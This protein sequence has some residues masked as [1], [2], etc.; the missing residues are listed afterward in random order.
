MLANGVSTRESAF[1]QAQEKIRAQAELVTLLEGQLKA[2]R[3]ATDMQIQQLAAQLQREQLERSM[4]EGALES[5]RKDI[6]RLM[7]EVAA[8]QYRPVATTPSEA[9]P[10]QP[11]PP[12]Q[13]RL[14]LQSHSQHLPPPGKPGGAVFT[15][16]LAAVQ[17]NLMPAFFTRARM[18]STSFLI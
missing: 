10:V 8:L 12:A 17:L 16:A 11:A 7:R 15:S 18:L 9:P 5:G 1:N 14:I 2:A 13:R 6:A 4:A 3:H